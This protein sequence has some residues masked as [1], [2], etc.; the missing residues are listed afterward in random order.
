MIRMVTKALAVTVSA[1]LVIFADLSTSAGSL[2]F[3]HEPD[4]P[5][6]L[7]KK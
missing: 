3:W 4:C 7:I 1:F 6:E 2:I 5:S